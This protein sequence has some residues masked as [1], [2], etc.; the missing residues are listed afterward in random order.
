MTGPGPN[1]RPAVPDDAAALARLRLAFRTEVAEAEEPADEFAERCERWMAGRLAG[2]L[3][4][5]WLAE[6]GGEA[7]GTAWLQ[8]LEKLPNPVAEPE[9]HGYVSSLYVAPEWRGSGIGSRLLAACLAEC[10]WREVDAVILWPTPRSRSL[11]LR[12]GFAVGED[13]LE[14]RGGMRGGPS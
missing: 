6:A 7:V 13:L 9:W 11:Y 5:A 2:P 3:W 4:R 8:V 12:H 10:E 14:R 1:V